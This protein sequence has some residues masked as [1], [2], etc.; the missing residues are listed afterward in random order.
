MKRAPGSY[1]LIVPGSLQ[2]NPTS[3]CFL[4]EHLQETFKSLSHHMR[5]SHACVT[6]VCHMRVSCVFEINSHGH[7][8]AVFMMMKCQFS[9]VEET[10]APGG[11]HQT[12]ASNC[13]TS[14]MCPVLVLT[15]GHSG[16]RL[17]TSGT[18]GASVN[19]PADFSGFFK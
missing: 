6:C 15:P 3:G 18:S 4:Q 7:I 12:T 9:L 8:E 1:C 13:H 10:G 11:N 14:S 16:V 19:G 17:Y 5:V 2:H